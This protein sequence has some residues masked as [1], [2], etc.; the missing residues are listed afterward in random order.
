MIYG[1]NHWYVLS[2]SPIAPEL[3]MRPRTKNKEL[4]E[5]S[6]GVKSLRE[7]LHQT[8][9][10]F[11]QTLGTAITTIARYETG[12]APRGRSLARLVGIADQNNLPELAEVFRSAL[13]REL[14]SLDST[15]FV[16][17]LEPRN[18]RE[19]LYVSSV[20]AILRNPQYTEV[21]PKLNKALMEAA[22]VSIEIVERHKSSETARRTA[23]EMSRKGNTP[24]AIAE[25]LGVPV[26]DVRQFL[27]MVAFVEAVE[28]FKKRSAK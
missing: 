14:G 11:A 9:Q 23:Q 10:Q 3:R 12:R 25:H 15:G 7:A 13:T 26:G 5:L 16:L 20:L 4:G 1:N 17:D 27:N 28:A 19:R 22:R 21:L 6:R 8:Q 18:D 2:R 24:E